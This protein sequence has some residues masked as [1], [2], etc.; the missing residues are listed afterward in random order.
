MI[1]FEPTFENPVMSAT[2]SDCGTYRYRL[3]R[4]WA[5]ERGH[6]V[7]VMLNPSTADSTSDDPTVR[8]CMRYA[9]AW[10]FGGIVVVNLFALRSPDPSP[11]VT[12][13]NPY[14]N[15]TSSR[16]VLDAATADG[17]KVVVCAW[18]NHGRIREECTSTLLRLQASGVTPRALRINKRTGVYEQPSH[19]LYLPASLTP[20]W[21]WDKNNYPAWQDTG[22]EATDVAD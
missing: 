22:W 16:E 5:P 10:G 12:Y 3:S 11:L 15:D 14:G 4:M 13:W 7:F 6:V 20:S 17:A 1:L 19:P 2:I 9:R 8:R 21:S 18:G